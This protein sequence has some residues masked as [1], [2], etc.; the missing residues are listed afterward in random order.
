LPRSGR[1]VK[2]NRPRAKGAP[3]A[4]PRCGSAAWLIEID[5]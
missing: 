3:R 1:G 4:S 5:P 2:T